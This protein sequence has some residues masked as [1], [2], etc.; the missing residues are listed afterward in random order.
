V[1]DIKPFLAAMA[2]CM[3]Q[4]LAVCDNGWLY[5]TMANVEELLI[6]KPDGKP[7]R[8]HPTTA[9]TPQPL[10]LNF[11]GLNGTTSKK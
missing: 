9:H 8:L 4:W 3:R 11:R 5:A 7:R 10:D 2:G 1:I 6:V